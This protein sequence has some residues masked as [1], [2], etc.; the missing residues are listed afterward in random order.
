MGLRDKLGR[1]KGEVLGIEVWVG[2]RMGVDISPGEKS[3]VMDDDVIAAIRLEAHSDDCSRHGE[4][5]PN[6]EE[7]L[8]EREGAKGAGKA[9]VST[10]DVVAS[11]ITA[12]SPS[13]RRQNVFRTRRKGPGMMIQYK[14]LFVV[15]F[16]AKCLLLKTVTKVMGTLV[17]VLFDD[18]SWGD[19]THAFTFRWLKKEGWVVY[20]VQGLL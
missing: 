15:A 14:S 7:L 19:V 6:D 10:A 4:R 13:E 11:D 3:G 20:K 5:F 17:L 1:F 8:A 9:G 18:G 12:S 16:Y 2:L